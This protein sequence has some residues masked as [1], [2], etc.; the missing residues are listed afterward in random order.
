MYYLFKYYVFILRIIIYFNQSI[1]FF[2]LLVL[3]NYFIFYLSIDPKQFWPPGG[4]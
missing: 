3:F 1:L 2:I 4:P